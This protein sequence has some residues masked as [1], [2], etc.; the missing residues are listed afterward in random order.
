VTTG[1]SLELWDTTRSSPIS[2]YEWGNDCDGLYHG[3]FNKADTN[4]LASSGRD[5]SVCIFGNWKKK[6]DLP[7]GAII[8]F[9]DVRS[10]QPVSR[11]ILKMRT[12]HLCWNPMQPLLFTCAN[13]DSNLYTFDIRRLDA[14]RVVHKD[15]TNAV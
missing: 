5:N 1:E 15:F 8:D 2:S 3:C 12:N 10:K 7:F 9:V 11:F 14:A 6:I 13:E 4:L